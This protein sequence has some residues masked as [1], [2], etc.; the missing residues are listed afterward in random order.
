MAYCITDG[1]IVIKD[2]G[3]RK[4]LWIDFLKTISVPV[5]LSAETGTYRY[6]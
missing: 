5:A 1:F 2:N 3:M 6:F 4:F